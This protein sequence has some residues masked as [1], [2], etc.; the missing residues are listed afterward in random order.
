MQQDTILKR[1][2]HNFQQAFDNTEQ[3]WRKEAAKEAAKI[4]A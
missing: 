3:Y 1:A 2:E 4:A